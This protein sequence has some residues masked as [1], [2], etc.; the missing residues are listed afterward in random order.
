MQKQTPRMAVL[1]GLCRIDEFIEERQI[2]RDALEPHITAEVEDV[3]QLTQD[4]YSNHWH[5]EHPGAKKPAFGR[6][7]A[8]ELLAK[9]GW[10]LNEL[11]EDG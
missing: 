5:A 9:L 11:A 4:G 6:E 8:I 3:A 7:S 2:F 10:L 1:D